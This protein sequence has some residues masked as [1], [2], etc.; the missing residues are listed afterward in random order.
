MSDDQPT[1][2][3]ADD[4]G[5]MSLDELNDILSLTIRH[6]RDNK[7][8]TYLCMLSAYTNNR[9]NTIKSGRLKLYR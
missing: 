8:I 2:V 3:S 7:L 4:F 6:D 1:K 5:E 9:V